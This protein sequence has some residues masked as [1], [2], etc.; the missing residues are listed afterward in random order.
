MSIFPWRSP[1]LAVAFLGLLVAAAT[2]PAAPERWREEIDR[3]TANDAAQPPAAG[4][5]VFVGSS[6][7][8]L[9]TTLVEDF[10]GVAVLNRGFG[11]S[12]LADSVFYLDRLVLPYRPR[13]VVL[14]A[15][16]NDIAGGKSPESLLADFRAFR[17]RIHAAL[18]ETRVIFLSIKESP[19]REK[20]RERMREANRLVEDDCKQI[21]LCT[22]V[23]V[24]GAM[25]TDDKQLRPELFREDRL[26]L[27]PAGYAIWKRE[28]APWLRP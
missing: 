21:P 6:S 8:R 20:W 22:F 27:S 11:G 13:I 14:Y 7:I 18:P 4:G 24:N 3:L 2:L 23:D 10:P 16:D 28:L 12:Q 19:A 1:S 5:V 26:H 9:W 17:Q 25:Q 15:G